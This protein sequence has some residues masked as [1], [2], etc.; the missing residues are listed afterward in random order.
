MPTDNLIDILFLRWQNTLQ[1]FGVDQITTENAFNNLVAAYSNPKRYYHTLKHI[2]HV[3]NTIETLQAYTKNLIAVQFAAW[4]HDIVYNTQAQDNE[5]KSAEYAHELL[6]NLGIPPNN[7]AGVTRLI[8]NTKHH[9]AEINDVDSQVLLDADLAILSAK[10]VQY[11]EYAHAIRQEYAWV[12][13][14]DYI[15]GRSQVLERFLQCDRIYSTPLMFKLA[16]QSARS[17]INTEIQILCNKV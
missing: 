7:I 16:E 14:A 4:F 17:N 13:D 12:S 9:Q 3:L 10:P 1:P 8:L 5:E 2:H 6:T 11:W 15:T